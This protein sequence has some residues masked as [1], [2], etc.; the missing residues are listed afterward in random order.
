MSFMNLESYDDKLLLH[1]E[2]NGVLQV[3]WETVDQVLT[4][5]ELF[6]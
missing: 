1:Q 6:E 2:H 4:L 5:R 3:R